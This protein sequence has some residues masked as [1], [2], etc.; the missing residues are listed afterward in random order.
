VSRIVLDASALLAV[1]NREPGA[2][3]LTPRLLSA[4]TSSTVNLAEVQSK[5]VSRGIGAD[6]AW[7]AALSPIREAA[8]FT[9]EQAK[10]AGSLIAQTSSLGLSLGDRACLALGIALKAPVYT[11]DGSWKSL[12]LGIRI[13]VVR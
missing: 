1:L 12:K 8:V 3:R 2:E 11:A 9:G 7:E 6:E 13:H 10:I 5:L 4:A